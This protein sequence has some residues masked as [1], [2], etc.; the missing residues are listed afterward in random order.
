VWTVVSRSHA[1]FAR[2]RVIDRT[3][4]LRHRPHRVRVVIHDDES[5]EIA[6]ADDSRRR[7]DASVSDDCFANVFSRSWLASMCAKSARA[8]STTPMSVDAFVRMFCDCL[9]AVRDGRGKVRGLFLDVLTTSQVRRAARGGDI[10]DEEF[11]VDDDSKRYLLATRVDK[12]I[13]RVYFPL[14]LER[15]G[16][17]GGHSQHSHSLNAS[18]STSASESKSALV[19]EN[20]RLREALRE[21][22]DELARRSRRRETNAT[23]VQKK[24]E[25]ELRAAREAKEA[26]TQKAAAAEAALAARAIEAADA[27][28]ADA[29]RIA[30]LEAEVAECKETEKRLRV[31]LREMN[32]R[33]KQTQRSVARSTVKTRPTRDDDPP[34]TWTPS[35]TTKLIDDAGARV[36]EDDRDWRVGVVEDGVLDDIDR[37]LKSLQT[38]LAEKRSALPSPHS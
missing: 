23:L 34:V 17:D 5:V 30:E 14:P 19:K 24:Q 16:G 27:K 18:T 13:G 29:A 32:A 10:E 11:D 28:A 22:K 38:F 3:L 8:S 37:R 21:V 36:V 35:Q 33:L 1:S 31:K 26:A 12:Y 15:V 20:A 4:P 7:M 2:M 9:D 6:L 25:L